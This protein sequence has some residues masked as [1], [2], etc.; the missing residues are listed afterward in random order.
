M[1][2]LTGGHDVQRVAAQA[3]ASGGEVLSF[4]PMREPVPD[5]YVLVPAPLA[6]GWRQ[7]GPGYREDERTRR[8][9]RCQVRVVVRHR[10]EV[11][12]RVSMKQ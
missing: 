6:G 3:I 11:I 10:R 8:Q 7:P 1:T 4:E 9:V 2:L 12:R 5:D